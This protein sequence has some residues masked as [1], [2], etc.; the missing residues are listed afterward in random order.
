M[1]IYSIFFIPAKLLQKKIKKIIFV[2]MFLRF[3][4]VLAA[5]FCLSI[6][7]LS[8]QLSFDTLSHDFGTIAED[9]GSVE[10]LF[11]CRNISASPIVILAARSSCG[12][13][14]VEF[15]RKPIPPDSTATLRVIFNPM[16]YP[17]AFARK[18]V[19]ATSEGTLKEQ[20]LIKGVVTP[21]HRT[22]EERY[23][24]VMGE[25]LRIATNAHIFGYIEHGRAKQSTFEVVNTTDN[26]VELRIDNPHPELSFYYPTT[27]APHEEA[28]INFECALGEDCNKYGTLSYTINM[29]IGSKPT[30]HPLIIGAMAIDLRPAQRDNGEAAIALSKK[31]IN[32][33]TINIEDSPRSESL[34]VSNSGNEPLI[35]RH[36]ES[37]NGYFVV[38]IV[39]DNRIAAGENR[40]IKVSINP[41]KLPFGGVVDKVRIVSNAPS[42]PVVTLRVSAIVEK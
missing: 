5:L 42:Q 4:T 26:K 11:R 27:L 6:G 14:K 41:S 10:Y 38:S 30:R 34:L 36:I 39:G 22:I 37:N 35:I 18:V 3:F 9:G 33:G 29:Y 28:T 8:A 20:L 7:K 24:I 23:P 40:E 19:I 17:G 31:F 25:G 12:C 16:N 2:A 15:S 1:Q 32:F 13:T 21:R